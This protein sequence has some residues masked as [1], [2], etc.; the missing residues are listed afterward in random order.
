MHLALARETG[1]IDIVELFTSIFL[2]VAAQQVGRTYAHL[3]DTYFNCLLTVEISMDMARNQQASPHFLTTVINALLI[4]LDMHHVVMM[5]QI[6]AIIF[7]CYRSI[8]NT[9]QKFKRFQELGWQ[10]SRLVL[11]PENTQRASRTTSRFYCPTIRGQQS[12]FTDSSTHVH[13]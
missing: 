5:S 7:R 13:T 4:V 8:P 1:M 12:Q 9:G 2:I 3:I 6:S 11:Q 10:F